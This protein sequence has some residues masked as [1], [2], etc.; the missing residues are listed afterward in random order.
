[1]STPATPGVLV[2]A[3]LACFVLGGLCFL[4]AGITSL[5]DIIRTRRSPR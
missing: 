3:A 2:L 4:A 5:T 1:M